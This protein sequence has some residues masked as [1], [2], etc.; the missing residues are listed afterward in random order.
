MY[1]QLSAVTF[2]V[3]LITEELNLFLHVGVKDMVGVG[4]SWSRD[5]L[6]ISELKKILN[7]AGPHQ[8]VFSMP[9]QCNLSGAF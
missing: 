8:V 4:V 9:S 2:L 7:I 3:V 1:K 6:L 5:N